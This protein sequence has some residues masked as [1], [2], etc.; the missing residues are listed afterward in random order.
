MKFPRMSDEENLE[1]KEEF[2]KYYK[3]LK[4]IYKFMA[5]QSSSSNIFAIT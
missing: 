2:W 5:P 3:Y 4:Q 1:V